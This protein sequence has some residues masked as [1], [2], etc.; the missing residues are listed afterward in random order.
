MILPFTI[1]SYFF[2]YIHLHLLKS[3]CVSSSYVPLSSKR[4][5]CGCQVG[6]RTWDCHTA[7]QCAS[8]LATPHP[9]NLATPHPFM[10]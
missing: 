9:I 5:P 7:V 6:N 10:I 4:P 8:N 3:L 2:T 1:H